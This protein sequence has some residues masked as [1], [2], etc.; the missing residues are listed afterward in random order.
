MIFR[1]RVYLINLKQKHAAV[2]TCETEKL[3]SG[4]VGHLEI[5]KGSRR[6]VARLEQEKNKKKANKGNSS[7]GAKH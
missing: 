5:L 7:A 3:L 6:E 4:R 1:Q 2:L